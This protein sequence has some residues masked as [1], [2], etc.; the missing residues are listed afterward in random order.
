MRFHEIFVLDIGSQLLLN[1]IVYK[2]SVENTHEY[3]ITE[4]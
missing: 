4:K 3:F 2:V 1:V